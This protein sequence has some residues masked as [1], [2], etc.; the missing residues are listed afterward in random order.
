M[1]SCYVGGVPYKNES[2]AGERQKSTFIKFC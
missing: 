1:C 2:L